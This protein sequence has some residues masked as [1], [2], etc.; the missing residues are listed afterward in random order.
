MVF[1]G[2]PPWFNVPHQCLANVFTVS[3]CTVIFCEWHLT[4]Y[5]SPH[6][7]PCAVE[8][9]EEE[10]AQEGEAGQAQEGEKG[11]E[12]EEGASQQEGEAEPARQ[13]YRQRQRQQQ[14]HRQRLSL[15]GS[16]CMLGYFHCTLEWSLA[17]QMDLPVSQAFGREASG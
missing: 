6:C 5:A 3:C 7:L 10:E 8:E 4:A 14:R 2:L 17:C 15:A 1:R 16:A 12:G 9:G 13:R 11:E